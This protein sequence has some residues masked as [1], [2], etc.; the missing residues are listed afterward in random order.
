MIF[1]SFTEM[2]DSKRFWEVPLDGTKTRLNFE[3][4]TTS[5]DLI[6]VPL[7]VMPNNS[8]PLRMVSE[9]GEVEIT[10]LELSLLVSY[11]AAVF[12]QDEGLHHL[13]RSPDGDDDGVQHA[14]FKGRLFG[15][16]ARFDHRREPDGRISSTTQWPS[17]LRLP[18]RPLGISDESKEDNGND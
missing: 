2:R 9:T 4:N 1:V 3:F 6:P 7:G 16:Q 13:Y 10:S 12:E 5:P 15:V 11:E 18:S 17:G 14:T 8:G